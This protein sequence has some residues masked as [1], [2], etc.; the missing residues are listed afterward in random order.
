MRID[1]LEIKIIPDSRGEDT[2]EATLFS[3]HL[4]VSASV[5]SGKSTGRKEAAVLKPPQALDKLDWLRSQLQSHEFA[6]LEQFD[7]LLTALD[8]TFNKQK[9]GGNLI[10]ALSMAFTKLLAG[11]GRMEIFEL[12]GRISGNSPKGELLC[13]FN[14][15]EGGVHVHPPAGG[16]PFQ[17]YLYIPQTKSVAKS[18]EE[19][20]V[21]LKIL[22]G[23]IQKQFG[24]LKQGDEG[25]YILPSSDPLLGLKIL[26]EVRGEQDKQSS[27]GLDVAASTLFSGGQ[28][29]LGERLVGREDL[30]SLYNQIIAD[31]PI[32]SIEDPF[33]EEDWQGFSELLGKVG[34]RVWIVG[35]DL[36]TTNFQRIKLA[37]IKEAVNAVIIKP[38]QIGTITETIQAANLARSFGWKIIVS[39]R[40]GETRE[41][42]IADLAVGLGA[43][44]FKSGCPLQKERLIKYERLIEIEKRLQSL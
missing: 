33:E 25:G 17:E 44:G 16:P 31:F 4:T 12:I 20:M 2:L 1:N 7:Q 8:G 39:H 29:L 15:I 5:P 21:F 23:K 36:T 19:V 35:D 27:L 37:K 42:F 28:Y 10:L 9:L 3:G 34:D 22:E 43:D 26:Q 38:N 32:L 11:G 13:F 14:L 6:T 40:S 18:L 30:V 41:T 24:Q